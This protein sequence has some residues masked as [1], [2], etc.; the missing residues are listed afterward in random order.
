MTNGCRVDHQS[1]PDKS[2]LCIFLCNSGQGGGL[3]I[4]NKHWRLLYLGRLDPPGFNIFMAI[5][6][7]KQKILDKP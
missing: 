2:F 3:G 7:L 1:V 6:S 5:V 4:A